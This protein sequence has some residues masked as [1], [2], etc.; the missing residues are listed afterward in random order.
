MDKKAQKHFIDSI[1][2]TIEKAEETIETL[3]DLNENLKRN[4]KYL[5]KATENGDNDSK[6]DNHKLANT[7]D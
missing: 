1:E 5:K 7:G 6:N 4:L 2:E 3:K